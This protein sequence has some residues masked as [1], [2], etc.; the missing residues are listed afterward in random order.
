MTKHQGLDHPGVPPSFHFKLISSHRSALSRQVREAV[1]IR[2]RGGAGAILNS[3]GEFNRC[4]IPRLVV[5]EEDQEAKKEREAQEHME[6]DELAKNLDEEDVQ[7]QESKYRDRELREK[8]RRRGSEMDDGAKTGRQVGE[9]R[10]L[11]RLRYGLIRK[12]VG[13]AGTRGRCT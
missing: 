8:K 2:R 1:R 10:V 5:E 4:H 6:K 3:K 12:R 11:K 9:R 13:R 7:W